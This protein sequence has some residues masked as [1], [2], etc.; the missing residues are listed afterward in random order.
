MLTAMHSPNDSRSYKNAAVIIGLIVFVLGV[1]YRL[2]VTGN[3]KKRCDMIPQ[4]SKACGSS[5]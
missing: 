5:F 1:R 3:W 4:G 2:L